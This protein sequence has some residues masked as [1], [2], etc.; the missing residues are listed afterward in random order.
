MSDNKTTQSATPATF[1]PNVTVATKELDDNAHAGVS[2]IVDYSGARAKSLEINSDRK[3]LVRAS[4]I[5]DALTGIQATLDLV[6]AKTDNLDVALS[7]R[8]KPADQQ[9]VIVDSSALPTG[10]ATSAKQDAEAILI[11]AVDE[12]APTTDTASSGLN[13]RLQRI[14]QRLSTL[15]TNLGTPFQA[16]GSIGNTT[17]ASTVADGANVTLGA[18]ADAKS[19]ATD[20]TAISAMSV[21]K[22]ISASVQAI[23]SRAALAATL[24]NVASSATNVTLLASNASRRGATIFNDSTAVLYVKFGATASA[25]SH[26]VQMAAGSY[27]ELPQPV[28]TGVIDGIWASANGSARITE[29]T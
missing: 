13:G 19:T 20:T 24:S 14:A 4:E 6:Q 3:A 11:G 23:A 12:T 7:T 29:L 5:E 1:D 22:Q 16:G 28:Y 18:K 26:V 15:I 10:T 25:T 21:W 2:V 8:T 9:H 27:Y 17:F